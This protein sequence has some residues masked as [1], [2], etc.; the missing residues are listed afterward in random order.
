MIRKTP[1]SPIFFTNG[2]NWVE[3]AIVVLILLFVADNVRARTNTGSADVLWAVTTAPNATQMNFSNGKN[4][5]IP[6]L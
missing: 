6:N 3:A 2:Y 4:P 1:P 5:I